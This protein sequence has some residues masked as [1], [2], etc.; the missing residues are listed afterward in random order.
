MLSWI[1]PLLSCWPNLEWPG[2]W[3]REWSVSG[4][5]Q[6][7]SQNPFFRISDPSEFFHESF[8]KYRWTF[9]IFKSGFHYVV[10]DIYAKTMF[11]ELSSARIFPSQ[12]ATWSWLQMRLSR[13]PHLLSSGPEGC[14]QGVWGSSAALQDFGKCRF[15]SHS[16]KFSQFPSLV[17]LR[18]FVGIF[19]GRFPQRVSG[20]PSKLSDGSSKRDTLDFRQ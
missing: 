13:P 12:V 20:C 1:H 7:T 14:A 6:N 15:S 17:P 4:R 10:Q 18:Q 5:S 19:R 9:F 2:T 11:F 8:K 16:S 3:N